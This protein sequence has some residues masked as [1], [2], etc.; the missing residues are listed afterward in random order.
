[1]TLEFIYYITTK[2]NNNDRLRTKKTSR[3]KIEYA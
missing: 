2:E 1:M 3:K